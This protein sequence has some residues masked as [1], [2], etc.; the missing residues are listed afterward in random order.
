MAVRL[1]GGPPVEL[2]QP[3]A[4]C[5]HPRLSRTPPRG[6]RAH[7][8]APQVVHARAP[9][10]QAAGSPSPARARSQP[11][12]ERPAARAPTKASPAPIGATTS[13]LGDSDSAAA[14]PRI[15]APRGP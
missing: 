9:A 11:I 6:G 14:A 7:G 10:A 4:N 5:P 15:T 12:S 3:V 8:C 13:A 2:A 1:V